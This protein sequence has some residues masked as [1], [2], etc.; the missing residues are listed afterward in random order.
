MFTRGPPLCDDQFVTHGTPLS[1]A[2]AI[3]HDGIIVGPGQHSKNGKPMHGVFCMQGGPPSDR[4]TH[5]R[6]RSTPSRCFQFRIN[7]WPT[8]WTVPCVLAWKPWPDTEV[9]HLQQFTDGCYKSCIRSKLDSAMCAGLEAVAMNIGNQRHMP[10]N[11]SLF[12][13]SAEVDSYRVLQ[14]IQPES[15]S[16]M[17]CG[18]K[19][20]WNAETK[21]HEYD[22]TYWAATSNNMPA[23]CGRCIPMSK[24]W[25]S[26]WTRKRRSKVWYCPDCDSGHGIPAFWS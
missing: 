19:T 13:N 10:Y 20:W 7:K 22:S 18:G 1:I 26:D 15:Q 11:M 25:T 3:L 9:S 16:Y 14:D 5:A 6:N 24:L 17:V 4:I 12:I 21:T 8:G 2:H 23:S